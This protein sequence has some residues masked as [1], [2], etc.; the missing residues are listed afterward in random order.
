MVW[1]FFDALHYALRRSVLMKIVN[2]GDNEGQK[3]L[4]FMGNNSQKWLCIFN[5][6]KGGEDVMRKA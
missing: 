6:K 5:K 1:A 4:N 2:H 3:V